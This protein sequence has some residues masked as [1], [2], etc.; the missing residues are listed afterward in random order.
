[1]LKLNSTQRKGGSRDY[2]THTQMGD[3]SGCS[4]AATASGRGGG[5]AGEDGRTI[6][7]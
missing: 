1:M 7:R 6:G 5:R 4:G 3:R 2:D